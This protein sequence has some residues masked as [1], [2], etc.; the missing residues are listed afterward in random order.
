MTHVES[1]LGIPILE[2]DSLAVLLYEE[3]PAAGGVLQSSAVVAGR[4]FNMGHG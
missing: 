3:Q 2:D 1:F 4:R